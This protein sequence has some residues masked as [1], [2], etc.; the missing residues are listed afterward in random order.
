MAHRLDRGRDIDAAVRWRG[1]QLFVTKCGLD[2]LRAREMEAAVHSVSHNEQVYVDE[3]KRCALNISI[4]A[5]NGHPDQLAAS[6]ATCIE[7]SLLQKIYK[8][9]EVRRRMFETML[10]EKYESI[11]DV[12]DCDSSLKCRRCNSVDVTW[13]QK[14][15]RS[16]DEA[17]T[18]FCVC[19][20]CHNRW[21]IR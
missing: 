1:I 7:G 18:V 11:D 14:Q 3:L 17:M 15:T 19:S 20:T 8:T 6:N 4:N 9:E 2:A 5:R 12:K 21:T 10:Q 16:A 13:E